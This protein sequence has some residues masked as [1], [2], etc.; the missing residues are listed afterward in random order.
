MGLC[1]QDTIVQQRNR[2]E[3]TTTDADEGELDSSG[4]SPEALVRY[5]LRHMHGRRRLT[6]FE[7]S[8]HHG[9]SR[10]A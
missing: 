2:R 9:R 3:F 5:R 4:V 7:E 6:Q 10:M 1:L 8:E